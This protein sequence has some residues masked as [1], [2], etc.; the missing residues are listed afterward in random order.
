M[1]GAYRQAGSDH[2]RARRARRLPTAARPLEVVAG[3]RQTERDRNARIA[4]SRLRARLNEFRGVWN[5]GAIPPYNAK[6]ARSGASRAGEGSI[7]TA[8]TR[9]LRLA[10]SLRTHNAMSHAGACRWLSTRSRPRERGREFG[11]GASRSCLVKL[12]TAE[13]VLIASLS[14]AFD[15]PR[16]NRQ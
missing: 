9:R 8:T 14:L 1:T 4:P 6:R 16:E 13:L 2:R 3:G 7:T 10:A 15:A 5:A 11:A 12:V